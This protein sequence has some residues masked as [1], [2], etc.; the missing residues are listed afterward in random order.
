MSMRSVAFQ[1]IVPFGRRYLAL[2]L[3]GDDTWHP[4]GPASSLR[5]DDAKRSV[6]TYRPLRETILGIVPFGRRYLAL[7]LSGD[8]TWH[9]ITIQFVSLRARNGGRLPIFL[10]R[11]RCCLAKKDR[12]RDGDFRAT[13]PPGR[14]TYCYR[15]QA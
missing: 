3:S 15:P 5:E 14:L 9:P 4:L 12:R 1:R 13:P 2:S 6:L 11:S 7:S 10:Q 8:D